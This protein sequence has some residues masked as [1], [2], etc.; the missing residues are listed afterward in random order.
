MSAVPSKQA[1]HMHQGLMRMLSIRVTNWCIRWAYASGTDAHPEHMHQFLTCMLSIRVKIPNLMRAL[2][3][4]ACTESTRRNWNKNRNWA[5]A[6]EIKGWLAPPKVWVT[7]LYFSPKVNNSKRLFGV[8]IMK[9]RASENLTTWAV[10]LK[11]CASFPL[12]DRKRFFIQFW[13]GK[14][15][16][17]QKTVTWVF[18][19]PADCIEYHK[20]P[21]RPCLLFLILLILWSTSLW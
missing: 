13:K 5:C 9:I 19:G 21:R 10:T 1:E 12:C 7:S 8:K 18:K 14:P 2:S 4:Y 15:V 16:I 3:T 17:P 6:S 20:M 11:N